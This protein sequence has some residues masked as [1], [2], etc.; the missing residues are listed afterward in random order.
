MF[1]D[2]IMSEDTN[3]DETTAQLKMIE[4][5]L[6]SDPTNSDLLQL[7]TDL[8]TLLSLLGS[9]DHETNNS[10]SNEAKSNQVQSDELT[11]LE[12]LKVKAP[13]S[14]KNKQELGVAVIISAETDQI[15]SDKD[16]ILVR[17]VFCHPTSERLVPCKF[18]L[19]G[20]CNRSDRDCRWSHGEIREAFLI[21]IGFI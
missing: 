6:I 12:G 11:K 10:S 21:I 19:D 15:Y 16:D 1:L 14:E 8:I 20:R 7:K 4:T 17:L 18:Y 5:A 2:I 13:V 9:K 3:I